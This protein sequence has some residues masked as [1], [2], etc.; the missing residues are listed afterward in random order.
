MLGLISFFLAS[1]CFRFSCG[2]SSGSIWLG[3]I[4]L[5]WLLVSR[6]CWFMSLVVSFS[7]SPMV[8]PLKKF[9][10]SCGSVRKLSARFLVLVFTI[11]LG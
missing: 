6:S 4:W 7:S 11:L 8:R 9:L 2:S 5:F 1:C 3:S 10:V